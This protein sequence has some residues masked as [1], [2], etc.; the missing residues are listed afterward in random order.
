MISSYSND[1]G[2]KLFILPTRRSKPE[3]RIKL[4]SD[5]PD[6]WQI[7]HLLAS[8]GLEAHLLLLLELVVHQK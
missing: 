3:T 7:A 5:Q 1:T 2:S 8:E 4:I 6:H